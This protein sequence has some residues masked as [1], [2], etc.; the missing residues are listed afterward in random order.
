MKPIIQQQIETIS[1]S[2][3][4]SN[5][6]I[7][8]IFDFLKQ[9][10]GQSTYTLAANGTSLDLTGLVIDPF[11]VLVVFFNGRYAIPST[12]YTIVNG[13]P[14]RLT[15]TAQPGI[16]IVTVIRLSGMEQTPVLTNGPA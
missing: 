2:I 16:T 6:E 8:N 5:R 12:D 11:D 13:T 9:Q 1:A 4:N 7:T 15:T 14:N 3:T 10:F